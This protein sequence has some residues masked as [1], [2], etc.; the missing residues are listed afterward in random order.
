[1]RVLV[2]GATGV[3]GQ[4]MLMTVP[5]GVECHFISRTPNPY[6]GDLSEM[7]HGTWDVV[8]NL[9]GMNSPDLVE[10]YPDAGYAANV[11]FVR[12][13]LMLPN[14]GH[15]VQVSTQAV[16]DGAQP[17][18]R[19][20]DVC[21]PINAYGRQKLEAE[22]LVQAGA[23]P[24]TI[25]RPTFVIGC[26]PIAHIGRMTALERLMVS[27]G[28][29]Q[30][31]DRWFSVAPVLDVVDLLWHIVQES[32]L[33]RG[34]VRHVGSHDGYSRHSLAQEVNGRA[35]ACAHSEFP[36]TAPRP[37]N[38]VYAND[39]Y[40]TRTLAEGINF[41]KNVY[42]SQGHSLFASAVDV[43]MFK[44]V[45][46][47]ES[48][49]E[50]ELGFRHWHSVLNESWRRDVKAM[51]GGAYE[52]EEIL[53]WYRKTQHYI[54]ELSTYH[55]DAGFNYIGMLTG[56]ANRLLDDG[57]RRVLVLGDGIGT[58]T[59]TFMQNG[60]DPVYHDLSG[61]ETQRFA[62]MS[63]WRRTGCAMQRSLTVD[64]DPTPLALQMYDAVV[65]LDFLEHVP[66]V[67]EW[68]KMIRKV[69]PPGGL[70]F[71]QNAFNIGSEGA[72]PCHLKVND[73]YEKDWVPLLEEHGFRV[74]GNWA[75]V[76]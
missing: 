25:V 32:A 36:G 40:M 44:Q 53:A 59:R 37:V 72:I 18:Y 20:T 23:I 27:P 29:P 68:V 61:S 7:T 14:I 73:R 63:Y 46:L 60:L 65:T 4:T 34:S 38:T 2:V 75:T 56:I 64:F 57:K 5:A 33:Y 28:A 16:F 12:N 8:I 67:P 3:I 15:L 35:V 66:N 11:G 49:R 43:A 17:P 62:T 21:R 42:F 10:R 50:L 39:A 13:L 51:R 71:F 52:A 30:S 47:L 24:Y 1:M 31:N 9:Y 55:N 76:C 22:Q 6:M 58:A 45:P 19:A 54:M 48:R 74:E 69:L 41:G 26:R 70:L